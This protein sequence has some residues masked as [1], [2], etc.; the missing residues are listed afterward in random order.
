MIVSLLV[1]LLLFATAHAGRADGNHG[2]HGDHGDRPHPVVLS[3]DDHA[4]DR[5]YSKLSGAWWRWAFSLPI[6]HH[7]L[8]DTA[9]CSAGQSGK[10]WFLGATFVTTVDPSGTTI[11]RANRHCTVPAGTDLF[12]PIVNTE[13]STLEGNGKTDGELR[14][15]AAFF[16]DHAHD[17]RATIDDVPVADLNTLRVQSPLFKFG[18]L[19]DNN[20]LQFFLGDE[21]APEGAKTNAVAD[22]VHLLVQKLPKGDHVI[23]FAGAQSFSKA[24]GDPFDFVFDLDITYH[25]TVR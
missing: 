8:F 16:Q 24:N 9:D 23:R 20:V 13:C 1:P 17:L 11:A 19:P 18:P 10:V 4:F 7:P 21:A 12:F 15:C 6:D 3:P 5:T 25:V 2:N 22:G 14:A